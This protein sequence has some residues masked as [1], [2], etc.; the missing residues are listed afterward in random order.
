MDNMWVDEDKL[1][2]LLE[3]LR[4]VK[5]VLESVP[6]ICDKW[7]KDDRLISRSTTS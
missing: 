4:E 3:T 7:L 6:L 2:G 5:E 1:Q